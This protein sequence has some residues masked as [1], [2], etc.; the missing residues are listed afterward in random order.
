MALK[1]DVNFRNT[2]INEFGNKVLCWDG[3]KIGMEALA[4][5]VADASGLPLEEIKG[6]K[7][8]RKSLALSEIIID[9]EF[10]DNT[11]GK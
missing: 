11:Y 6:H 1:D 3:P 8:M 5:S 4:Q 7:T 9:V 10:K 2:L